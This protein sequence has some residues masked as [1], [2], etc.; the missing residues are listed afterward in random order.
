MKNLKK[1]SKK[2][3]E[4]FEKLEKQAIE[5]TLW[6]H[7]I[8][9][10]LESLAKKY[11]F[12]NYYK[13]LSISKISN[14]LTRLAIEARKFKSADDFIQSVRL[15][16]IKKS[17]EERLTKLKFYDDPFSTR[18]RALKEINEAKE[19][20]AKIPKNEM[21]NETVEILEKYQDSGW[22]DAAYNFYSKS[23]K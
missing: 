16:T 15:D 21:V 20:L 2:I 6:A 19:E 17:A 5:P 18:Q 3:V 23:N 12:E 13:N 7:K 11:D 4:L 14:D 10:Q 22:F 9:K 1:P 8:K